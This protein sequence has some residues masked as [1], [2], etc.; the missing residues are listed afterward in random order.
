MQVAR[1]AGEIRS[2]PREL[3][4]NLAETRAGH[5]AGGAVPVAQK[6]GGRPLGIAA[7]ALGRVGFDVI[8][9]FPSMP[10]VARFDRV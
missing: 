5:L 4:K 1:I 7:Q 9:C 8:S 10:C 3:E 6:A 2:T